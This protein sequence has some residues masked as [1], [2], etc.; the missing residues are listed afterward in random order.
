MQCWDDGVVDDIR[1]T[2]ILRRHGASASFNLNFGLHGESRGHGWNYKGLKDVKRLAQRELHQVYEGF[3]VANH[4]LTHP[5]LEQISIKNA[6]KEIEYNKK[7]LEQHFGYYVTGFAYPFGTYTPEIQEFIRETGHVYARV[8][9]SADRVFPPADP[10]A[11]APSTHFQNPEFWAIFERAKAAGEVF[12][13]WGHSYENVTEENWQDFDAKIARIAAD[14]ETEW[15]DLTA[16]FI[17]S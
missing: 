5:H 4:S 10:F 15:T 8:G 12:Y 2:E 14:P 11:F 17:G 13:F 1:L 7:Q 6:R 9:I 16:L 3:T